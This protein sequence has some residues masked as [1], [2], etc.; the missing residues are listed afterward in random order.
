MRG[1]EVRCC[2]ELKALIMEC[3]NKNDKERPNLKQL[4]EKI[5]ALMIGHNK[6][7]RTMSVII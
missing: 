1:L 7:G 6:L 4:K 5:D 2:K 3:L